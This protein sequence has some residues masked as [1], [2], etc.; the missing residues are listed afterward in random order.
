MTFTTLNLLLVV[1]ALCLCYR[2]CQSKPLHPDLQ[3]LLDTMPRRPPP[4]SAFPRRNSD[5]ALPV[6]LDP[7][8]AVGAVMKKGCSVANLGT[9][10]RSSSALFRVWEDFL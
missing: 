10:M 8:L 5:V 4:T 6:H 2:S 9:G 3:F 7:D 1:V